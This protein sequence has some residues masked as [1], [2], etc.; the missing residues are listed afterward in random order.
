MQIH[1]NFYGCKNIDQKTMLEGFWDR[2]SLNENCNVNRWHQ[3]SE[4]F[5]RRMYG[6]NAKPL[7]YKP[8]LLG[9]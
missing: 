9:V 8:S 7:R 1:E 6:D 2:Q 5:N 3:M 4:R